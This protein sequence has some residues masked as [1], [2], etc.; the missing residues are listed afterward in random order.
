MAT[1]YWASSHNKKWV[2]DRLALFTSRAE[3]LRFT[4]PEHLAF[5][6]IFFANLIFKIGKRLHFR[7]RVIATATVFFR[8]FYLKNHLCDTEPY[9]VLVACCYLAGKAEE[10]PAHI[11]NVINIANTVF[12]ELGVWPAPLDNHRLAEMEFYLVDE[13]ECDLTVFH[14]YRSLLA[15]CGKE[16]DEAGMGGP[17]HTGQ[18]TAPDLGV[19]VIS[20][21]RYWGTGAGKLLLDDRTLQL[22]WLII[23]DTYRTDV[24]LLYPPFLIAIAAI[25]LSLVNHDRISK[26]HG[27]PDD[28][29]TQDASDQLQISA[30]TPMV[31]SP[32]LVASTPKAPT[33]P[34]GPDPITFLANL[35]VSMATVAAIAQEM[36]SFYTLS[37]RY[38][39][40][41]G[42]GG[43]NA[44]QRQRSTDND[45]QMSDGTSESTIGEKVRARQLVEVLRRMRTEK[46]RESEGA[47]INSVGPLMS[48]TASVGVQ[49]KTGGAGRGGQP[50]N[51]RLERAQA[52][53]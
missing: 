11:K 23:N 29:Q 52:V 19:G 35:N 1:D 8:R 53:G 41:S 5:L 30:S 48:P 16:T 27:S 32:S 46:E 28:P 31:T 51:K 36:L 47:S 2:V 49:G 15:L 43:A 26:A 37:A 38:V 44:A 14:P 34:L 40:D 39:D 24:C 18:E 17:G 25:Y 7:Q 13:L 9:I 42:N 50:V 21:E 3:D 4:T 6:H 20:G 22:A 12:G 10:L 45:V 33:A